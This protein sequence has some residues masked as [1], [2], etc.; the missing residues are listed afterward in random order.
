[1]G[2][3]GRKACDVSGPLATD[4]EGRESDLCIEMSERKALEFLKWGG[5]KCHVNDERDP[6]DSEVAVVINRL[7][8][9]NKEM[10]NRIE[11]S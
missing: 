4:V 7:P 11:Y 8:Y 2:E 6:K 5:G 3:K 10:K 9:T 1:M